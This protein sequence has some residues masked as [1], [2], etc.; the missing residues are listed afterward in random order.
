ML[1]LLAIEKYWLCL[2]ACALTFSLHTI[3]EQQLQISYTTIG[4]KG[5]T[6]SSPLQTLARMCTYNGELTLDNPIHNV[7]SK[8]LFCTSYSVCNSVQHKLWA[9]RQNNMSSGFGC[10]WVISSVTHPGDRGHS[11]NVSISTH[12]IGTDLSV[13]F[14]PAGSV[15][16]GEHNHHLHHP[17]LGPCDH[18]HIQ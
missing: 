11:T 5:L 16:L 13:I 3:R 6:L 14:N 15:T 17:R 12:P 9:L 18:I 8:D 10:G 1:S 4:G 7:F 2:P